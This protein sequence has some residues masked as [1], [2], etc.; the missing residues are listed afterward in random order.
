MFSVDTLSQSY[1]STCKEPLES[2]HNVLLVHVQPSIGDCELVALLEDILT[3]NPI[4][5]FL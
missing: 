4:R 2:E 3:A 1:S 5:C